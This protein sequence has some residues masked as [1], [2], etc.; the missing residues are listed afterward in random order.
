MMVVGRLYP[1]RDTHLGLRSFGSESTCINSVKR[2]RL[3]PRHLL[4][5]SPLPSTREGI[6]FPL[7]NLV[8]CTA[9]IGNST[10]LWIDLDPTSRLQSLLDYKKT[11]SLLF[12]PWTTLGVLILPR[13]LWWPERLPPNCMA[14]ASL[15]G[16][17]TW[18]SVFKYLLVLHKKVRH[19]FKPIHV[20][21][22]IAFWGHCTSASEWCGPWRFIRLGC[23]CAHY[24][25]GWSHYS[26]TQR[27]YGLERGNVKWVFLLYYW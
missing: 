18:Y 13:T 22:W 11:E 5:W 20:G 2:E 7:I 21:P 23:G 26:N 10:F 4:T 17:Q 8:L 16:S 15:S 25:K 12:A 6:P 3:R 19:C 24:Y 27:A 14:C 9:F 1:L